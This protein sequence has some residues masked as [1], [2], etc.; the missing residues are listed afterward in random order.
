M[1]RTLAESVI[2]GRNVKVPMKSHDYGMVGFIKQLVDVQ[3]AANVNRKRLSR[4]ITRGSK[5]ESLLITEPI[6]F[7]RKSCSSTPNSPIGAGV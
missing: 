4:P 7:V 6:V 5:F 3:G 2:R 1:L